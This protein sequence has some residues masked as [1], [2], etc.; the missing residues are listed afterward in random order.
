[1]S[2]SPIS[3]EPL[4][5]QLNWRYA[6]KKFDATKKIPEE[7]WQALEDVL[8]LT[9]SSFGLQ[10]WKFIVVTDPDLRKT[11]QDHAWGQSQVVDASHLVVFARKLEVSDAD[12]DRYVNYMAE[13][14]STPVESLEGMSTMIKGFLKSPPYP[15]EIEAWTARQTYIAVGQFLTSAALL[16]IDACPMEGFV[17]SKVDD[18]LE[19]TK[20]GYGAVVLCAAGYRAEDDKYADLKKVRFPQSEMIEYR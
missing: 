16:G 6:V 5:Q 4:L 12:V 17:P 3:S 8:V 1:M 11:L 14:R 15:M 19:L 18:T 7:T 9:P 2:N 20:Q 10:P 13:V